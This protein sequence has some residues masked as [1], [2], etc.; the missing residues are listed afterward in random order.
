MV[1]KAGRQ[2]ENIY[3]DTRNQA[4]KQRSL[5]LNKHPSQYIGHFIPRE[6]GLRKVIVHSYSYSYSYLAIS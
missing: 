6:T 5:L 3:D 1:S 2:V 4:M